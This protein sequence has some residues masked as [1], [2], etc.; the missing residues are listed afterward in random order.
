M[1]SLDR[2][3]LAAGLA[4]AL[5]GLG[6]FGQLARSADP[7]PAATAVMT[8]TQSSAASQSTSLDGV[9]E[10]VRQT[11]LSSQV[12]GAII[13]LKVKAGDQVRAGQELLRIDGRAAQENVAA[14][15]AQV[16]A[17]QAQAQV[18]LRELE[19]QKS[20]FQKQFISQ[21]ALDR[22]Q[23]QVDVAQA[24]VRA[25]HAQTKAAQAQS[26]FFVI[27][28]PF[29]GVVSEVPVVQGDMAMPGRPLLT[30]YDPSALRISTAVPQALLPGLSGKLEAVR[31]EVAGAGTQKPA[32]LE[33]LPAA[34][35]ITHSA[36][37]RL[38]LAPGQ[39]GLVPGLFAKV[40]LPLAGSAQ[41]TRVYLPAALVV[42]RA[43]M[44]G[45][46]VSNGQAQPLLRQ[47]RLGRVSGDQVEV[48]SGLRPGEKAVAAPA[49]PSSAGAKP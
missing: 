42:R 48:L 6:P 45:V 21:T 31:Y 13:V 16:A 35:P 37:L 14:S 49:A 30:L 32:K 34:D 1:K 19:R 8:Q 36:T 33:L 3:A 39:A 22:A 44:T 10:A 23:A 25:L 17:A 43:E 40:F 12:P 5:L 24:Q 38:N 20:L 28:A 29:T 15:A 18:A 46:Y 27:T 26:G 11:T 41:T 4:A 7:S 9:V 2:K 47:V